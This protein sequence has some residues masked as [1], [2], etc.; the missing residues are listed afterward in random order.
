MSHD[1]FP[2]PRSSHDLRKALT[3]P[4]SG[5]YLVN[6]VLIGK[7]NHPKLLVGESYDKETVDKLLEEEPGEV[8]RV[9]NVSVRDLANYWVKRGLDNILEDRAAKKLC[10]PQDVV[11]KVKT[12]LPAPRSPSVIFFKSLGTEVYFRPGALNGDELEFFK[13]GVPHGV[14]EWNGWLKTLGLQHAADM[15]DRC[16]ALGFRF[17]EGGHE[18]FVARLP[19]RMYR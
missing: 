14:S 3:C 5:K 15:V 9:P 18:A 1:M 13:G 2:Q 11:D 12:F 7:S 6:P 19:F 4:L 16:I 17:E 8:L 10:L